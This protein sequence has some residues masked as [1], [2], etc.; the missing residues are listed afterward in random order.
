MKRNKWKYIVEIILLAV[1]NKLSWRKKFICFWTKHNLV[2]F[3]NCCPWN[4][5][6]FAWRGA[7]YS[8]K[9]IRMIK[10]SHMRLLICMFVRTVT[11]FNCTSFLCDCDSF[12][13]YLEVRLLRVKLL[14]D[15]PLLRMEVI[16]IRTVDCWPQGTHSSIPSLSIF[17]S[18]SGEPASLHVRLLLPVVT[19]VSGLSL[20]QWL[21]LVWSYTEKSYMRL[22][23][24]TSC[25]LCGIFSDTVSTTD[26]RLNE[27]KRMKVYR[28]WK[29]ISEVW[30]FYDC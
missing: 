4:L 23:Y 1:G 28:K 25:M 16:C 19:L 9:W 21:Q 12:I 13:S 18:L 7:S 29:I 17:L 20:C 14:E 2:T 6:T 5:H 30:D 3:H 8:L 22:I 24:S 27:S 10:W 26:L 11:Y 15:K